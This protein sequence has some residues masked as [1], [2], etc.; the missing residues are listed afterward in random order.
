MLYNYLC[1]INDSLESKYPNLN[2]E[3]INIDINNKFNDYK[4]IKNL[5]MPNKFSL[6]DRCETHTPINYNLYRNS[7]TEII[8]QYITNSSAYSIRQKN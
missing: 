5:S 7:I 2:F 4:S 8:R 1:Q 6:S 3:I